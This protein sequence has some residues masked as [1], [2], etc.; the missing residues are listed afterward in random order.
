MIDGLG[1]HEVITALTVLGAGGG[2]MHLRKLGAS[3]GKAGKPKGMDKVKGRLDHVEK[4]QAALH[5]RLDGH[6]AEFKG[7]NDR[8]EGKVDGLVSEVHGVSLQ[9]ATLVAAH[10]LGKAGKVEGPTQSN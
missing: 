7:A 5:R 2:V 6:Q 1:M 10:E 3:L 4:E 9:L 8:L